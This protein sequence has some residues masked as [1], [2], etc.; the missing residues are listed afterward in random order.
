MGF[1]NPSFDESKCALFVSRY[2][3]TKHHN[4]FFR[5][6]DFINSFTDVTKLLDEPLAD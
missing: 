6:G 5:L 1:E 2:F 4:Y 3:G